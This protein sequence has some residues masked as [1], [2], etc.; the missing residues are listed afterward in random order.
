MMLNGSPSVRLDHLYED[1]LSKRLILWRTGVD[2][3]ITD[4]YILVTELLLT[5]Q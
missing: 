5:G 3:F 2:A 1:A 4:R